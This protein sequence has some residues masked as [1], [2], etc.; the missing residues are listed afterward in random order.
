MEVEF[1]DFANENELWLAESAQ[2]RPLTFLVGHRSRDSVSPHANRS[3]ATTA[4]TRDTASRST[5]G[6]R[7]GTLLLWRTYSTHGRSYK[8]SGR[9]RGATNRRVG[10]ECAGQTGRGSSLDRSRD[11]KPRTIWRRHPRERTCRN[12]MTPVR[13]HGAACGLPHS[14]FELSIASIP[15]NNRGVYV[16]PTCPN[17][18]G[19][20]RVMNFLCSGQP[21]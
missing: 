3:A 17:A 11:P 14:S 18:L 1:R 21:N 9:L 8:T 12:I 5:G 13:M 10:I 16:E 19:I 4:Y 2:S 6:G 7:R 15:R 20:L